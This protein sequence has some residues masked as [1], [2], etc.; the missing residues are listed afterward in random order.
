MSD[1]LTAE[2]YAGVIDLLRLQTT[3]DQKLDIRNLDAKNTLKKS[4]LSFAKKALMYKKIT[5]TGEGT[6]PRLSGW[7]I[8][9]WV[10]GAE[11]P[12]N[13]SLWKDVLVGA[14]LLQPFVL[15]ALQLQALLSAYWV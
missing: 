3:T 13:I 1:V 15:R 8:T 2:N 7:L 10:A 9:D 14:L 5:L 12:K 11:I 4:L 6:T